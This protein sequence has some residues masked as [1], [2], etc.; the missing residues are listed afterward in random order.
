[1]ET[2]NG[3]VGLEEQFDEW[4]K[5][6][7]KK[8]LLNQVAGK[9]ISPLATKMNALV[10]DGEVTD[11]EW[12]D[13]DAAVAKELPIMNAR[14][15]KFVEDMGAINDLS[16]QAEL[17]GLQE[18]IKSI[19]ENTAQE[20]VAYMNSL[21]FLI[22]DRNDSVANIGNMLT[23]NFTTYVNPM[24]SQLEAMANETA[25]ISKL[26]SSIITNHPNGGNC[27]RVVD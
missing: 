7:V 14:M 9:I 22:S 4:A 5:N 18:G 11:Q 21:R 1:M 8:Q 27:V 24:L 26:L 3:L 25:T 13:W 10:K 23:E 2:G 6:L 12:A 20:I 15:Q 17:G 16:T 19:Q